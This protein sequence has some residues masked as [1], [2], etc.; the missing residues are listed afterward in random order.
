M[1]IDFLKT[2]ITLAESE[3][4]T[5]TSD[6]TGQSQSVISASLSKLEKELGKPLFERS[7]RR[8]H[9]NDDGRFFLPQARR[10]VRHWEEAGNSVR[11]SSTE[12]GVVKVG[13]L[14][15]NDGLYFMFAAFQELYPDI[16]I[17][18]YDERTM[19]DDI[20]RS[21]LDLF[22]VP[23]QMC[24]D[25]PT[26]LIARQDGL[27]LLVKDSSPF[28]Q[29]QSVRLEELKDEQFVFSAYGGRIERIYE[30]CRDNGFSPQIAY[31]CEN[32]DVKI[33]LILHSDAIGIVYN[34]MRHFR[35]SIKGLSTVPVE[36]ENKEVNDIMVAWRKEPLNP[37]ARVLADFAEEFKR[38]PATIGNRTYLNNREQ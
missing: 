29:K 8:L 5:L 11:Q 37:L 33:D 27:F 4:I 32:L 23:K 19:Q 24:H 30:L 31:L 36:L 3:N 35:R 25:L 2:F 20:L 16:R 38:D 22:V 1:D 34:T 9:L 17:E 21:D 12:S 13:V 6:E 26:R 10:I 15:E 14:I 28:A 7:G 18:L